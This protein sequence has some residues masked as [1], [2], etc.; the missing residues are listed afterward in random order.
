MIIFLCL[1]CFDFFLKLKF[2]YIFLIIIIDYDGEINDG[3]DDEDD[4]EQ[5]NIMNISS[6]ELKNI[7]D[8]LSKEKLTNIIIELKG[9]L[10]DAQNDMRQM[11]N[12]FIEQQQS[13]GGD[14]IKIENNVANLDEQSDSTYMDSYSHFSIHHTMLADKP[15]TLAYQDAIIE[16]SSLFIGKTVLDIGCGTGILSLFAAKAGAKLVVAVDH[17][18]IVNNA[19]S[20]IIE[21]GY[22]QTIR[23]VRGKLERLDFEKLSLPTKYDIIISEWM[24]YFLLFEG[25][26]DTVLY[27]RDHLLQPQGALLPSRCKIF[28]S[29]FSDCNFY[30]NNIDFW[31]DVYGFDMSSMITDVTKE[32]TV[33]L[34]SPENICSAAE[35]IFDFDLISCPIT[36]FANELSSTFEF[37]FKNDKTIHGFVGWFDCYFDSM[38]KLIILSTSPFAEPTHWK[39]TIFPLKE[40]ILVAAG[41]S[42]RGEI[43]IGKNSQ[44]PR[45]LQIRLLLQQPILKLVY[46]IC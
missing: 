40:P 15:R 19:R 2:S 5:M 12:L 23:V 24:G 37:H 31:N 33:D 34:I 38:T 4:D 43:R 11:R 45:A 39:Q 30:E 41:Q 16:N 26:L 35:K 29:T 28:L 6:V 18:D 17:S 22:E 1:V 20:I 13:D 14:V 10:N 42:I 46:N 44:N 3:N 36:D 25:M 27:A 9:K 7:C 21:N 8:K 32:A